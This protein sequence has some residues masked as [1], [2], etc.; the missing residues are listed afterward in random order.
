[1]IAVT[2]GCRRSRP[3]IGTAI[4]ASTV[5][6]NG[7]ASFRYR[8][9]RECE[10]SMPLR[11]RLWVR[12][13]KAAEVLRGIDALAGQA[14]DALAQG[15]E[16]QLLGLALHLEE[17]VERLGNRHVLR[18]DGRAVER[19]VIELVVDRGRRLPKAL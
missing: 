4:I 3:A 7:S 2:L 18:R 1:M 14:L 16:A 19:S 17:V 11:V 8:S 13:R 12:S 10:A 5:L 9:T 6:E 15:G